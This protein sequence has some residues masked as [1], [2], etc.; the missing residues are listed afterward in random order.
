[1]QQSSPYVN[2]QIINS[3][4]IG[5]PGVGKTAF[6]SF[7]FNWDPVIVHHSTPISA[8]PVRAITAS[9]VAEDNGKWLDIDKHSKEL[10]RI[11]ADAI[12]YLA[13]HKKYIVDTEPSGRLEDTPSNAAAVD[14][15]NAV[16]PTTGN[17]I[18][19]KQNQAMSKETTDEQQ[20]TAPISMTTPYS[21][22]DPSEV[23][24][25]L[26]LLPKVEGAGELLESKWVY[27][28]D[29][30]GQP[31]FADVSRAFV[32]TNSVYFI[33]NKLTEKLSDKPNFC[34]SENGEPLVTP[35]KLRMTNLQLI[36]HFICSI[37]SSKYEKDVDSSLVVQQPFV[38]VI[39]THHDKYLELLSNLPPVEFENIEDKNDI[40]LKEFKKCLNHFTFHSQF[41]EIHLIHT[42]NNICTGPERSDR[43]K[44]LRKK[45]LEAIEGKLKPRKVKIPV[46]Q[47]LFD[48]LIKNK[49]GESGKESH[50]VVTL[51]EC[52]D[53]GSKL[54][55]NIKDTLMFFDS[56]NLYLYFG[57]FQPLQHIVFTNPQYLLSLLSK[58]IQFSFVDQHSSNSTYALC[59]LSDTGIF[60]ESFT[61]K[62]FQN[63]RL[64]IC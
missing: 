25:I 49:I 63:Q 30:G 23:Q 13:M 38:N 17:L 2:I 44:S 10:F 62:I 57:D 7:L 4:L 20:A 32:R 22:L 28:L 46:H 24:D 16:I 42:V 29:T 43:S 35:S 53:I 31:Q 1:M 34:Y 58:L 33:L 64:E 6:K 15:R 50:G 59:I 3:V 27:L 54:G 8:V 21:V 40:L 61:G 51:N 48:V 47:Y 56:L 39:G 18:R 9:K 45:L 11:L 37:L 52:S 60:D 55:I 19:S 26:D 12:K 5:P 36:K 14:V 41:P